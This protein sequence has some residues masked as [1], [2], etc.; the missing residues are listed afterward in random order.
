M[1]R[2]FKE[3][4]LADMDMK[5]FIASSSEEEDEVSEVEE[6]NRSVDATVP[7]IGGRF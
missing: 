4:D 5:D 7:K 2:R 6:E 3:D 1:T